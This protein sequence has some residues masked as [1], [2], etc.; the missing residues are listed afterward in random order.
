MAKY[1]QKLIDKTHNLKES[2]LT[3]KEVSKKLKLKFGQVNY[4]LYS[5]NPTLA[6]AQLA[7]ELEPGLNAIF[8]KEQKSLDELYDDADEAVK[9]AKTLIKRIKRLF[10]GA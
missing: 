10:F 7:K 8:G 2:G 3:I 4:I 1:S 5:K 9:E 6:K